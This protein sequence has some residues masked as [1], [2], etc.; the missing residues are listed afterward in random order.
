MIH[1]HIRTHA[2]TNTHTAFTKTFHQDCTLASRLQASQQNSPS[3]LLNKT[4]APRLSTK[5]LLQ[6]AQLHAAHADSCF[7][8]LKK[9]SQQLRRLSWPEAPPVLCAAVQ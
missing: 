8:L 9:P 4:L 6:D 1:T 7:K 3:K 5:L 2:H